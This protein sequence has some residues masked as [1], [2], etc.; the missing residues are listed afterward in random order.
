MTAFSTRNRRAA[1]ALLG[2]A[3]VITATSRGHRDRRSGRTVARR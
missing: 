3:A 1:L 2:G